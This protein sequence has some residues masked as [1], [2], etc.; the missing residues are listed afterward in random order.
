MTNSKQ[1][2]ALSKEQIDSVITL[3][4]KGELDK[5][6]NN[7]NK[8]IKTFPII[9]I[10]SSSLFP[11]KKYRIKFINFSNVKFYFA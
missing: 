6:L 1:Q 3:F 7:A 8:L 4:S 11:I 9:I 2:S 10:I 5:A